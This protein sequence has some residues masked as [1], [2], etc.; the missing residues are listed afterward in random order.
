MV[1][2]SGSGKSTLAYTIVRLLPANARI[3]RGEVVFENRSLL[4]LSDG[5]MKKIRGKKVTMVFQ[6]PTTALNPVFRIKDQVLRIIKDN[7]GLQG[8]PAKQHAFQLLREVELP[9]PASIFE[10]FPF[11][12]SGGMQQRV[13]MAMAL[14]SN[15][16]LIIADEPTSAVDATIQAQII[17]LMRKLRNERDFS[18]LLITHSIAVAREICDR[19]AVMYAGEIVEIGPTEKVIGSPKHPYTQALVRSIP[20]PRRPGEAK[21]DLSVVAGQVPDLKSPPVGCRF[22]PRC[23]FVMEICRREEPPAYSVDERRVN[24]FLYKKEG[25]A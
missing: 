21:A 24:C 5:E 8:A 11:E 3:L 16:R 18:M 9:D 1:G 22:H 7:L 17:D 6:D 25:E 4:S 10:A 15:P 20:R 2:E 23:P 12:L 13:M 14:S 19:V